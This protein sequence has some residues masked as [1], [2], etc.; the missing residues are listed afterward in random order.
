MML[1]PIFLSALL[2]CFFGCIQDLKAFVSGDQADANQT[3]QPIVAGTDIAFS[4]H[5]SN[6]ARIK[7][8]KT[9]TKFLTV[10]NPTGRSIVLSKPSM[11]QK[12]VLR[13]LTKTDNQFRIDE[14]QTD[15]GSRLNARSKCV[16]AVQ[17]NDKLNNLDSN[18]TLR[19]TVDGKNYDFQLLAV[20]GP[21]L[22]DRGE[23]CTG[24]QPPHR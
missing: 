9:P 20:N 1:R 5:E 17:F 23:G 19:L 8:K 4:R 12:T 15:C 2:L 10:W 14:K 13:G 11:D 24:P 21:D 3:T 18:N 16:I 22:R 7:D 6:C